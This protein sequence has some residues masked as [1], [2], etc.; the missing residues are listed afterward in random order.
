NRLYQL[1]KKDNRE[2]ILPLVID[3]SHPTPAIGVNNKERGSF[4][5]R[6]HVELVMALALIHHLVIGKNISFEQVAEF[7]RN[8]GTYLLI[9]FVPREDEKLQ[10][11]LS[12]KPDIYT[13][14]NQEIFVRAFEKYYTILKQE[15]IEGSERT[16]YLMKTHD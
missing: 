5:E 11:M 16:L 2:N 1:I 13:D 14:Y 8:T 4:S 10:L 3:L 15:K 9:E 7:F 12:Q 6:M